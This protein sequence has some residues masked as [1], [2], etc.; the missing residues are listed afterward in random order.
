MALASTPQE[1]SITIAQINNEFA[2]KYETCRETIE[3]YN[4]I[5]EK[6][7]KHTWKKWVAVAGTI[8]ITACEILWC[9]EAAK[10]AGTGETVT[11]KQLWIP[12]I[13]LFV[14]LLFLG[15]W[16][17]SYSDKEKQRLHISW[18]RKRI[19]PVFYPAYQYEDTQIEEIK[20]AILEAS[21]K[22][23]ISHAENLHYFGC[24]LNDILNIYEVS[25]L[26]DMKIP[27]FWGLVLVASK[28]QMTADKKEKLKELYA[29]TMEWK[30]TVLE[31]NEMCWIFCRGLSLDTFMD[32]EIGD[33]KQKSLRMR[34][35]E[36]ERFFKNFQFIQEA[37]GIISV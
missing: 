1:E 8:L 5:Y 25:I 36:T 30:I 12:V 18:L 13:L 7:E 21:R 11:I 24:I 6:N 10:R 3:A 9:V 35:I 26:D 27:C 15:I 37:T 22:A 23:G 14:W 29:Q 16:V 17:K 19:M 33:I 2:E 34:P 31:E 28:D 20:E 4:S 32:A